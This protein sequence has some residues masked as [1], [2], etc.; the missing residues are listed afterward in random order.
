M[1]E[2]VVAC[3]NTV[4]ETFPVRHDDRSRARCDYDRLRFYAL[5][6]H[7]DGARFQQS[8]FP[9]DNAVAIR[10]HAL[11]YAVHIVVAQ[12]AYTLQNSGDIYRQILAAMDAEIIQ[13]ASLCIGIGDF[14]QGFGWHA[15][16]ACTGGAV[17][18]GIDQQKITGLLAYPL[19]GGQARR[20]GTDD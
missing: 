20:T 10:F 8:R 11:Q 2:Q 1:I 6:V 4:A 13:L 15:A 3:Q 14:D 9:V 12:S 7:F 16:G 17:V 18:S 5:S 19:N